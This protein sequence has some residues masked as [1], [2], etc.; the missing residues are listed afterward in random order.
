MFTN[1]FRTDDMT[2]RLLVLCQMFLVILVA[3]EAHE[4]VV[5]RT[6]RTSRSRTRALVGTVAIMYA[7][8]HNPPRPRRAVRAATRALAARRPRGLPRW[9]R[10]FT[11]MG[12][13]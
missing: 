3:M 8:M 10:S 2:H 6:A 11:A 5:R 12:A 9:R 13:G 7:R 1:R 4:G